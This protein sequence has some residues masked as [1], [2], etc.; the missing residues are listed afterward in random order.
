M[1]KAIWICGTKTNL[2]VEF[3]MKPRT[4]ALSILFASFFALCA[5]ITPAQTQTQLDE[6]NRL[7]EKD[8]TD[9]LDYGEW[10]LNAQFWFE[11]S[12]SVYAKQFFAGVHL[13]DADDA[14]FRAVVGDYVKRH[15]E[16]MQESYAK[17]ETREWT[18]ED[19][20]K[21]TE[22]LAGAANDAIQQIH[23]KLTADGAKAVDAAAVSDHSRLTSATATQT[24]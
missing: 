2:D 11:H 13:S 7:S 14:A 16:L 9:A 20:V 17:V 3:I 19:Q 12:D 8:W 23:S 22:A 21:L 24:T 5:Q 15:D 6:M 18:T 4:L 1:A 10:L